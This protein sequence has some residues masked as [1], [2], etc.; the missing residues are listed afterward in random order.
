MGRAEPIRTCVVCGC[1]DRKEDLL[2]I[3]VDEQGTVIPDLTGRAPGRGAWVHPRCVHALEPRHVHRG[4][5][6]RVKIEALD[7]EALKKRLGT[8]R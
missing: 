1:R 3:A 2:R 5:R 8:A 7:V 6:G 4:F